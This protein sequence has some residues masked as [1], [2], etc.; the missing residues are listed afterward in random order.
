MRLRTQ[1][2]DDLPIDEFG[3]RKPKIVVRE[4][5]HFPEDSWDEKTAAAENAGYWAQHRAKSIAAL[6]L[7][8]E[9]SLLWEIGA[10]NGNVAINLKKYDIDV[11]AVEPLEAGARIL[12]NSSIPTYQATLDQLS[13]PDGSLGAIGLF[14]VLE[15]V[16]KPSELL[17]EVSRVLK[18]GG[19]LIC[20]V[21][22]HQW[23]FSD[24]DESIGHF[25]RYSMK[26]LRQEIWASGFQD[27]ES[28]FLFG[29]LLIPAFVTRRI[30]YML[31]RR[32]SFEQVSTSTKTAGKLG[33][34]FKFLIHALLIVEERVKPFSGLSIL[35]VAKK[36]SKSEF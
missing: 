21:P 28:H 29:F 7:Q 31:G 13:L 23:L 6:L 20:S 2:W 33:A 26:T 25:R 34:I 15:H 10:G 27:H 1:G 8:H 5:I 9:V 14:D 35:M 36:K 30:P 22:A 3:I 24:F 16:D 11:I 4:I 12:S 32:R 19:V 18:P 17:S